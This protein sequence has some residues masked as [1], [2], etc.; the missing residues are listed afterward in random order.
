MPTINRIDL[1]PVVVPFRIA[2]RSASGSLPEASF[3]LIDLH[4]SEE[5]VGRSYVF[6]YSPSMLKPLYETLN[7][8]AAVAV[9][10]DAEPLAVEALL[11]ARFKLLDT[12][13]LLGIAVSGIDMA[14]WDAHAK[15]ADLPLA[16]ML[17]SDVTEVPAYNSCGLW[18]QEV[19]SIADEAEQLL[20]GGRFGAVKIRLGRP[21]PSDDIAAIRAVKQR[22]G[23]VPLMC[24]Y[25]QSQSFSS[26]LARAEAIDGEGLYWIEEPVYHRDYNASA[27][28]AERI[29]TPIQIG[30]NFENEFE[31]S[32][33]IEVKAAD[34]YMP[35]VQRIGGVSGWLRASGLASAHRIEMSSHLFPE[36]SVHL[37]A[38]T[39]TRHWL[40]YVD[41]ANPLLKHP[42]EIRAG[43]AVVPDRPGVGLEW[44]NDAVSRY[45]LQN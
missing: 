42:L 33:A 10:A 35:D 27:R 45:S 11:S 4:T 16:S 30:E 21:D 20:D 24:D 25:N 37:L 43:G 15:R 7:A 19:A 44:D 14:L 22:I 17:G 5:I 13:G 18:I 8:V 31:M 41:W 6:A 38:A 12:H 34:Y 32:C 2:P 1:T 23:S 9:N 29:S 40:E 3:V 26:A 36:F 28:I 39:P